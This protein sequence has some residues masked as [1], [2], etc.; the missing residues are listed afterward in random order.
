M[1]TPGIFSR[2][3]FRNTTAQTDS[4]N[5]ARLKS[6]MTSYP[7]EAL[8]VYDFTSNELLFE[9]GWKELL[10]LS[11]CPTIHTL[12][13]RIQRKFQLQVM[14]ILDCLLKQILSD[15]EEVSKYGCTI[16]FKLKSESGPLLP[17]VFRIGVYEVGESGEA[18]SCIIR[19][20][21]D[22]SLRIGS[23]ARY[24]IYA[25]GEVCSQELNEKFNMN[26]QL[27]QD[28]LQILRLIAR[29]LAFKEVA[30]EMSISKS[31]VEKRVQRMYKRFNVKSTAH[32]IGHAYNQFIL[33]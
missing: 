8:F 22:D 16:E 2:K 25:P 3:I 17:V 10:Q 23:L 9:A 6:S 5:Y 11:E 27:S 32:L 14:E 18:L 15:R 24:T 30:H 28:E 4:S 20:Q 12:F 26:P 1:N 21:R 19:C 31:T 29:G 33:P 7:M 13:D